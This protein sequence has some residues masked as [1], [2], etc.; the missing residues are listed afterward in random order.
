MSDSIHGAASAVASVLESL[1]EL[2][3]A[4]G[5]VSPGEVLTI[6]DVC[7]WA[8]EEQPLSPGFSDEAKS[9]RWRRLRRC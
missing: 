2:L 6:L 7:Q 3:V 4:K 1:I 9:R 8:A 5:T